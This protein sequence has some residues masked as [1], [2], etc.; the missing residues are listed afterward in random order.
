M[1]FILQ[2]WH[3]AFA[4]LSGWVNQ[5]QQQIIEFQNAQIEALLKKLGNKRILL[6]DEQRRIKIMA[7]LQSSEPFFARL[8][9]ACSFAFGLQRKSSN[10]SSQGFSFDYPSAC[11]RSRNRPTSVI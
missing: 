7:S 9:L 8:R 10:R 4:A 1:S 5:R 6:T 3:L 11:S 2:P